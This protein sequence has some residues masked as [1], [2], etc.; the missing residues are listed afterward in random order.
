M[1]AAD[2]HFGHDQSRRRSV[3]GGIGKR[4]D[5]R[6]QEPLT[7]LFLLI[8]V[9]EVPLCGCP[10]DDQAEQNQRHRDED[11]EVNHG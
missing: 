10:P 11:D 6:H 8:Q 9:A 4:L 5:L 3:R 1:I 2:H 7:F